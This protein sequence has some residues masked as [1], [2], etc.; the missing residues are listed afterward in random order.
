MTEPFIHHREARERAMAQAVAIASSGELGEITVARAQALLA[1]VESAP[2]VPDAL[3]S[4]KLRMSWTPERVAALAEMHASRVPRRNIAAHF[5]ITP[6]AVNSCV[7]VFG[8]PTRG[9]PAQMAAMTIAR[10]AQAMIKA[11][12]LNGKAA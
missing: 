4:K 6:R 3:K 12:R 10:A 11:E 9:T 7:Y 1:F 5:G 2:V 8:L